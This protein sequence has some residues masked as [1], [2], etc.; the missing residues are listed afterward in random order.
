[1][2]L[3]FTKAVVFALGVHATVALGSLVVPSRGAARLLRSEETFFTVSIL[4][5]PPS[6]PASTLAGEGTESGEPGDRETATKVAA[7]RAKPRTTVRT[8]EPEPWR[9]ADRVSRPDSPV[10]G[11]RGALY[12]AAMGS[13]GSAIRASDPGPADGHGSGTGTGETTGPAGGLETRGAS[14]AES[15]LAFGPGMTRP[16]LLAKTDPTY[17]REALAASVQGLM[18]VKCTITLQ[19]ALESCRIVKS[20]PHMD[21]AVLAALTK[22]RYTPVT[23]Q[24]RAVAVDYVIP[25]RLVL[26]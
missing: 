4:P 3:S 12:G 7:Q 21:A 14:G 1:V 2:S 22:W 15:V 23:Y 6:G 20:L 26:Q 13:E 8:A 25:V 11:A 16:S 17:T 24:G 10:E 9:T 5:G 18:L 19:G